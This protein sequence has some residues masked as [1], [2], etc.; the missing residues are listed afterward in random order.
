MNLKEK[1]VKEKLLKLFNIAYYVAK[2]EE[3]FIK[4]PVLV[5]LHFKN[6]LHLGNTYKNDHACG[7]FIQNIAQTMTDDL[8]D[9]IK[10]ARFF[11]VMSDVDRSV[12]DQEI[13][14]ITFVDNG[15]PVY[16][17][18]NMLTLQHANSQG[19]L[20]AIITGL[21]QAGISEEEEKKRKKR[22]KRLVG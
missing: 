19:I 6:G 7:T 14:Y 16:N 3:P 4:Y 11:S 13:I 17:M 22:K 8:E 15:L 20:D 5:G 10:L 12:Q 1:D 21:N 2:E 9:R 18:V